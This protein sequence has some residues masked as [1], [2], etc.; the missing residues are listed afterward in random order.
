MVGKIWLKRSPHLNSDPCLNGAEFLDFGPEKLTLIHA[1]S[2]YLKAINSCFCYLI[3]LG[4]S[5]KNVWWKQTDFSLKITA[6]LLFHSCIQVQPSAQHHSQLM[7]WSFLSTKCFWTI[8]ERFERSF[9][10][11]SI[12][13]SALLFHPL[14]FLIFIFHSFSLTSLLLAPCGWNRSPPSN[15]PLCVLMIPGG[16]LNVCVRAPGCPLPAPPFSPREPKNYGCNSHPHTLIHLDLKM[17]CAASPSLQSSC[18]NHEGSMKQCSENVTH[19]T[20]SWTA[21]SKYWSELDPVW[22]RGECEILVH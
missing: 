3:Q 10:L 16:W 14:S 5:R 4:S 19:S 20:R 6:F 8:K 15:S 9:F 1:N 7:L 12:C 17:N 21:L 2:V 22:G 13:T 18:T 11:S